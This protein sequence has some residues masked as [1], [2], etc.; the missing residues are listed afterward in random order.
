MLLLLLSLLPPAFSTL[1]KIAGFKGDRKKGIALLWQAS[2]FGN[3]N[4]AFA[5]LILL[6]Y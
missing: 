3:L 4:G 1:I 5:G 2:K 6:G